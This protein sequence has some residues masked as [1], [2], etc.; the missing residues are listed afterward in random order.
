[1]QTIS[2]VR[3]AGHRTRRKP[4]TRRCK[5]W[6]NSCHRTWS[7]PTSRWAKTTT[8]CPQSHV[9]HSAAGLCSLRSPCPTSGGRITLKWAMTKSTTPV[10]TKTWWQGTWALLWARQRV[11]WWMKTKTKGKVTWP[12]G[13]L[14]WCMTPTRVAVRTDPGW[15]LSWASA[16][17]MWN[18]SCLTYTSN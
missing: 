16:V 15:C 14:K 3:Q 13:R 8:R 9:R 18:R 1:M 11:S 17:K 2:W 6:P 4:T 7:H 12:W 5:I 10:K